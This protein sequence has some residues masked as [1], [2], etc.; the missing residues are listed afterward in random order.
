[1]TEIGGGAFWGCESLTSVTIPNG[2]TELSGG[3][4]VAAKA[5][6]A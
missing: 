2:V 3:L 5:L 4:S 6:K 1:M